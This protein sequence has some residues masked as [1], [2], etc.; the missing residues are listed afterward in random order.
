M[1]CCLNQCIEEYICMVAGS[2]LAFGLE[3]IDLDQDLDS[4][5]LTCVQSW[6]GT[7]VFQKTIGDGIT[8]VDPNQYS[9][10]V[11]PEDTSSVTAGK[12]N[13]EL[14]IGLNSDELVLLRGILEIK[15][16]A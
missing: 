12:Y 13:Y 4:A 16:K 5:S 8:K 9:V 15:A 10:R 3:F 2:T 7:Q 6:G 11:E 1:S 14:R